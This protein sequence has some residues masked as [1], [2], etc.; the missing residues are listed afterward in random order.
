MFYRL[1]IAALLLPAI[2]SADK[3]DGV[4]RRGGIRWDVKRS[5]NRV[6]VK[7]T[8][9]GGNAYT[10]NAAVDGKEYPVNGFI[11]GTTVRLLSV[12]DKGF[13]TAMFRNGKEFSRTKNSVN[14]DGTLLNS[15]TFSGGSSSH[16]IFAH[17]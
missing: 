5:A 17:Y 3:I 14:A 15:E 8:A 12:S 6:E 7:V 1:L 9:V 2:L 16:M 11:P 4:W 13:E 10:Y